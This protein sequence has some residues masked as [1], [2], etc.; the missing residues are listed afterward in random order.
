MKTTLALAILFASLIHPSAQAADQ[1]AGCTDRL[2]ALQ[3]ERSGVQQVSP[4]VLN[5]AAPSLAHFLAVEKTEGMIKQ[6]VAYFSL[7]F[8]TVTG[9]RY[10]IVAKDGTSAAKMTYY[11]DARKKLVYAEAVSTT[12][13]E[14][15]SSTYWVCE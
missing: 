5:A 9:Y 10:T 6:Y 7:Q 8:G 13:L 2:Q 1:K 11:Q 14:K 15:T 3:G 12:G 4:S